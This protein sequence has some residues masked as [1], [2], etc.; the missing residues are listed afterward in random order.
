MLVGVE[1]GCWQHGP[2]AS[3]D[4][5]WPQ[6]DSL[7]SLGLS[8]SWH[9]NA[10]VLHC[11]SKAFIQ[12]GSAFPSPGLW[13]VS[14]WISQLNRAGR[15][16]LPNCIW[17]IS[18]S[19]SNARYKITAPSLH[20]GLKLVLCGQHVAAPHR[21]FRSLAPNIFPGFSWGTGSPWSTLWAR[22]AEGQRADSVIDA[23]GKVTA[24]AGPTVR[25]VVKSSL[26]VSPLITVTE[27]AS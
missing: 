6:P 14:Y 26:F 24:K 17:W 9:I 10:G 12:F 27:S 2:G 4:R 7:E 23:T 13:F 15:S 19:C 8:G 25:A 18:S 3:W 16:Y 5:G 11:R 22:G 1:A 21:W 20:L